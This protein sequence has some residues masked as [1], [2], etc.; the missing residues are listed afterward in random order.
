MD[1]DTYGSEKTPATTQTH[2]SADADDGAMHPTSSTYGSTGGSGSS[3]TY[4]GT[5]SGSSSAGDTA[6]AAKD[7]AGELWTDAKETAHA[8]LNEQKDAAADGIDG[9]AGALRDASQKGASGNDRDAFAG[10]TGSAADGL[11][12][13]SQTLRSKD[14]STMLR[15]VESFAR[16]QPVAFFGLALA[17][18]FVGVRF[19]KASNPE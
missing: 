2:P 4:S 7:K 12:R 9:V 10:L 8:K 17:V 13:L 19:L 5:D 1:T 14:V 3:T 18:G 11:D 6:Q 16:Q 15:D